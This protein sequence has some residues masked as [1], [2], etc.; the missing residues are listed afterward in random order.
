MD[1]ELDTGDWVWIAG[2]TLLA[3]AA[4]GCALWWVFG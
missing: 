2:T 1:E 3:L 4:I